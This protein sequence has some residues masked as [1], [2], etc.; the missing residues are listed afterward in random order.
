MN[1]KQKRSLEILDRR[2]AELQ[3][4]LDYQRSANQSSKKY[5][6]CLQTINKI[7]RL[8]EYKKHL[9]DNRNINTVLIAILAAD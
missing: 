8:L 6:L 3:T 9:E 5:D 1:T 7:H 4:L 2:I